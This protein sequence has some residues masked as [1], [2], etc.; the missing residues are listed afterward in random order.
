MAVINLSSVSIN[1]VHKLIQISIS[2]FEETF[3]T[4][5]TAKDMADCI[6]TKFGHISISNEINNPNSE[7]Y[8]LT[9]N[10]IIAGYLKLNY[11]IAQTELQTQ[12]CIEIERIYILEAYKNQKLGTNLLQK[13]IEIAKQKKVNFIWLGVWEHNTKAITF[14]THKGFKAFAT[15]PYKLGN[16][17][18]MDIMMKLIME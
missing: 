16:D 13:A 14:Y 11:G 17:V 7:F 2:T 15:H 8:L 3:A 12:N 10:S 1:E 9:Y 6:A 4:Q 18:Q 5:N